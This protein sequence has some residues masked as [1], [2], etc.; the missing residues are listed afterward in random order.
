MLLR[1]SLGIF[2]RCHIDPFPLPRMFWFCF[3]WMQWA[4]TCRPRSVPSALTLGKPQLND[5]VLKKHCSQTWKMVEWGQPLPSSPG[6]LR[7]TLGAQGKLGSPLAQ[8]VPLR[9]EEDSQR[10]GIVCWNVKSGQQ[11]AKALII[12]VQISQQTTLNTRFPFSLRN[13][14]AES[15][16]FKPVWAPPMNY[17]GDRADG[18]PFLSVHFNRFSDP[19]LLEQ[20]VLLFIFK[21]YL[22]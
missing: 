3:C 20:K 17:S 2:R 12:L 5:T 10:S 7:C 22:Y 11:D 14:Y 6:R 9:R 13:N 19:V 21:F 4:D 16:F 15:P 1:S 18:R 8:P